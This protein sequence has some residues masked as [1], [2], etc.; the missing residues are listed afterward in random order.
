[1]FRNKWGNVQVEV[2]FAADGTLTN[3]D[4]IQTPG[5]R[6]KSIEINDYAVPQLDADAVDLQSA[7]VHTI[8]GATYTSDSY[9]S[10][11]QSA[12]DAARA[13]GATTLT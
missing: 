10:S 13:A 7:Q 12:I 6:G 9:R 2:T 1:V 5:G 11:L 3:V 8:S 4:A